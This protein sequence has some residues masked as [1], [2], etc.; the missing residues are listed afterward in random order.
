[1]L[2]R[3]C[4]RRSSCATSS[5]C[6]QMLAAS[7]L[8]GRGGRA[9]ARGAP[10]PRRPRGARRRARAGDRRARR[11]CASVHELLEPEVGR[12]RDLRSRAWCATSA[13]TRAPSSTSM[14]R[15]WARR[16]AAAAATTSCSGGSGARCPRWASRSAS[17]ACTSRSPARSAEPARCSRGRRRSLPSASH[18][19]RRGGQPSARGHG[20]ME[21][22]VSRQ[23]PHDRGARAVRCSSDTVDLLGGLG[24]DTEELRSQRPQAAVRG[25][26]RDHDAPVRRAHLRRGGR[27]RSRRHR[28]GRAARAGRRSAPASAAARSTS[29][30]TSATAAARWCSPARPAPTPRSRRCAASA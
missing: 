3:R 5:G 12:A 16:S 1:M 4:S 17:T 28:Q 9:A 30:S 2:A 25:H 29:C 27:R 15:R 8:V 22:R 23:R 10:A 13:T 19:A 7:G 11:A 20:L 18:Q 26:R 21:L 24:L 14:T 6:E